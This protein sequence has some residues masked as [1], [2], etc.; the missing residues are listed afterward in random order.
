MNIFKRIH[1]FFNKTEKK[2]DASTSRVIPEKQEPK[3]EYKTYNSTINI[4]SK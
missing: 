3:K 2:E 1:R 4:G